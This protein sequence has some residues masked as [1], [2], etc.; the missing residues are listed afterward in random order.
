MQTRQTEITCTYSQHVAEIPNQASEIASSATDHLRLADSIRELG[1]TAMS[2]AYLQNAQRLL[3]EGS[4]SD[5][6]LG[7]QS[8][9][10]GV[11]FLWWCVCHGWQSS[12][13]GL[14]SERR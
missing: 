6:A 1:D 5:L 2:R 10:K 14:F 4:N 8:T 11:F 7:G 3:G 9:S 13:E 12:A